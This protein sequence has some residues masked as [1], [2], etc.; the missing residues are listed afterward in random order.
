[1]KTKILSLAM[2]VLAAMVLAGCGNNSANNMPASTNSPAIQQLP[3][4][5]APAMTNNLSNTN[6]PASANK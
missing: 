1:M 4:G 6:T 3:S 2:L 5:G